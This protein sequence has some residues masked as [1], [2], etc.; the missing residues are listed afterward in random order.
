MRP[1]GDVLMFR[2]WFAEPSPWNQFHPHHLQMQSADGNQPFLP[3]TQVFLPKQTSDLLQS[4]AKGAA[5][6]W[7]VQTVSKLSSHLNFQS[8][9]LKRLQ[10]K[11]KICRDILAKGEGNQ[12]AAVQAYAWRHTK[13][14]WMHGSQ[15]KQGKQTG[16]C[17]KPESCLQHA[18]HCAHQI[19]LADWNSS[20]SASSLP[21]SS[22]SQG[23]QN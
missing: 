15:I 8:H 20:P 10:A 17:C 18:S 4:R 5:I 7:A 12:Q 2:I 16:L 21:P 13:C 19:T 11:P 3:C 23:R 6:M 22:S 9:P 14:A 1:L